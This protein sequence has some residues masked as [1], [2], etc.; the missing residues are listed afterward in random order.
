MSSS[1]ALR[2]PGIPREA[3]PSTFIPLSST[4]TPPST[5]GLLKSNP[6]FPKPLHSSRAT[7]A[8]KHLFAKSEPLLIHSEA[9]KPPTKLQ[10][11][12]YQLCLLKTLIKRNI[13]QNPDCREG[14][15]SLT[16]RASS[17]RVFW[18]YYKQKASGV[19]KKKWIKKS[20][21]FNKTTT[22]SHSYSWGAVLSSLGCRIRPLALVTGQGYN[23]MSCCQS[24]LS[25]SPQKWFYCPIWT[26]EASL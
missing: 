24:I 8:P 14:H 19:S 26:Q 7:T 22:F 1:V 11:S 4:A 9:K 20:K 6:T 25:K 3:A 12:F 16:L 21:P 15:S 10:G 5:H 18:Y 2:G 13:N 23:F 17:K